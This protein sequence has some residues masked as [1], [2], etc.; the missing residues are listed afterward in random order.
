[1]DNSDVQLISVTPDAEKIIAYCARVSSPNQENS[2]YAKLLKYCIDHKHWSVFE[3]ADVT[4]EIT[5]SRAIAQQI[6][7][8]RSFHFQEFSQ[9]YAEVPEDAVVIYKARAQDHKNR[10]NSL[11]TLEDGLKEDWKNIQERLWKEAREMYKWALDNGIAKECARMIL[12][13]QTKTKMYMKGTVRDWIHYINL[14][15]ANGTQKEHMEIAE[16]IKAVLMK[17]LP[18]VSQAAWGN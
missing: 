15:T 14:R 2:D 8:H 3:M 11:D 7:R 6:L 4:V 5:T 17:E 16:K 9:R 18:T 13:V 12:P 1:M 10:Q